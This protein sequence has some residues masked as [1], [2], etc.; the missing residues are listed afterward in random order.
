MSPLTEMSA[1]RN[2]LAT[3]ALV[4]ACSDVV[5]FNRRASEKRQRERASE[6]LSAA[7]TQ[8]AVDPDQ[9]C[10]AFLEVMRISVAVIEAARMPSRL[11]RITGSELATATV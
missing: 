3:S 9:F 5:Y 4:P 1:D 8:R 2:N 7:F 6:N 11:N 10:A